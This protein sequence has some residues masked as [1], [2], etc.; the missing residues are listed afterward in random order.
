MLANTGYPAILTIEGVV[1]LRKCPFANHA[2]QQKSIENQIA[3]SCLN[4]FIVPT[5][6]HLELQYY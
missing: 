2:N 6:F 5:N 1:A 3:F 4:K